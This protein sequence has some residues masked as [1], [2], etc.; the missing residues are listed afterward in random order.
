MKKKGFTL[1][2]HKAVGA[3]LV[4][5]EQQLRE[6]QSAVYTAYPVKLGDS[7][8]SKA[9]AGILCAQNEL[10]NAMFREAH[11]GAHTA[12]YYQGGSHNPAD[13]DGAL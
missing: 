11:D 5:I 1:R 13:A 12:I 4:R 7:I 2:Q 9:I 8:F 3:R 6:L 10:E